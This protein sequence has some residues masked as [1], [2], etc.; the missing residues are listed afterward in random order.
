MHCDGVARAMTARAS[1]KWASALGASVALFLFW[2]VVTAI[3]WPLAWLAPNVIGF[4]HWLV[5]SP[6]TDAAFF[7]ASPTALIARDSAILPLARAEMLM[8][9]GAVGSVGVA[10]ASLAWFAL[11]KGERWA[12]VTLGLV[13][14]PTLFLAGVVMMDYAAKGARFALGD[15]PPFLILQAIAALLGFALGWKGT[16]EGS[17]PKPS[18][19]S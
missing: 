14:L 7:G 10:V 1:F 4:P 12:L 15:V 13:P 11:R 8:L 2:G 18:T 6:S 19:D 16:A 3:G 5:F 9:S 17:R